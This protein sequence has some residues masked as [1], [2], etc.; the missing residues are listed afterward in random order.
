MKKKKILFIFVKKNSFFNFKFFIFDEN[1]IFI[2][3]NRKH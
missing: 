1:L 2:F 3:R